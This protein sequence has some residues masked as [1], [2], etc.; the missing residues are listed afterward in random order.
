MAIC[1]ILSFSFNKKIVLCKKFIKP[2]KLHKSESENTS[3]CT[4]SMKW[5]PPNAK[6]TSRSNFEITSLGDVDVKLWK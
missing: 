4:V 2:L 5:K 3:L 1:I 6:Y